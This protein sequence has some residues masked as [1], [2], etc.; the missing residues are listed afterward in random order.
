MEKLWSPKRGWNFA[1]KVFEIFDWSFDDSSN[2]MSAIGEEPY[3]TG[4]VDEGREW[5]ENWLKKNHI[6][7]MHSIHIVGV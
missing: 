2:Y 4:K 3:E 7:G 5:F 1:E 6:T